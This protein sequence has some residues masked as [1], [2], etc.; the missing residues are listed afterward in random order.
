MLVVRATKKLLDRV[1]PPTL[2]EGECG[3]TLL[4]SWYAAA[5]FWKPQIVLLV[6]E[7][8]LLPV[9]MLLAPAA[10]VLARTGEQSGDVLAGYGAPAAV[11]AE[12][13]RRM[14]ECR[15]AKPRSAEGAG[16]VSRVRGS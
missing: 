15:I 10:T 13:H 1:G 9:L 11:L 5:L 14:R 3:T 8:T 4:G 7:A 2:G 6:N 16:L 12:E